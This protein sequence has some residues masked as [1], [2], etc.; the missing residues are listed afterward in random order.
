VP[1]PLLSLDP[2]EPLGLWTGPAAPPAA[3]P[4]LRAQAFE[5]SS[6]GDR[7]PGRLLLPPEGD[8]P[9]PVVLLQHGAGGSKEADYLT[10][11]AGPW[12]RRGVAVAS[13]DFPL[14]GE[15][16]DAK[17]SERLLAAL[18]RGP[19][20]AEPGGLLDSLFRQAVVDLRRT[21]D[22]LERLP[23]LDAERL[24]YAGF[25]MGTVIGAVFC[26][27]DPRPRAV[28]L[29]IGGVGL[30]PPHLDAA[31]YVGRIAP[32]PLLMVNTTE[33]ETFPRPRVEALFEAAAEP[34]ELRWFAGGHRELPGAALKAMWQ[35]LGPRLGV[36]P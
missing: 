9:F 5:L 20:E 36:T 13:I 11:T 7:V 30:G 8:G 33:D 31:H 27:V 24:A 6:C 2:D 22:A 32:R 21:A 29:A 18:L 4:E 12:A 26:G 3:Y 34:K 17:L 15:R 16:A 25:S 35:F 14:H 1:D 19:R 23:G 10:A 28:A